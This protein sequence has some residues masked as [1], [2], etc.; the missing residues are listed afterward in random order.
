MEKIACLVQLLMQYFKKKKNIQFLSRNPIVTSS[1]FNTW[2][3][4]EYKYLVCKWD[5]LLK[6]DDEREINPECRRRL[7]IL[8]EWFRGLSVGAVA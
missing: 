1:L 7:S 6:K 4:G 5:L 8:S 2:L 3:N